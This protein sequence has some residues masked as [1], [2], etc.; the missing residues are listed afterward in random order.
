MI[1][2]YKFRTIAKTKTR[3]KFTQKSAVDAIKTKLA[4][5]VGRDAWNIW[6]KFGRGISY[7]SGDT[8]I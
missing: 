6:L 2:A 1:V 8:T 4:W 3:Q 5:E 7:R